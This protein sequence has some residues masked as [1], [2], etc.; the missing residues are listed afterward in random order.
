VSVQAD[1]W[2]EAPEEGDFNRLNSYDMA[3]SVLEEWSYEPRTEGQCSAYQ[4]AQN[5]P[6]V[7]EQFA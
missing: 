2:R 1:T 7:S 4:R 6:H 5:A 3:S